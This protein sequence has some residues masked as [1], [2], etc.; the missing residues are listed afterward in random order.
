[1]RANSQRCRSAGTRVRVEKVPNALVVYLD[2]GHLH[3]TG[4]AARFRLGESREYLAT[5]A[6]DD[7]LV[8][9]AAPVG[10][11]HHAVGF[12]AAR[13]TVREQAHVVSGP[14]VL[15][16]VLAEVVEHHALRREGSVGGQ[17]VAVVGPVRVVEREGGLRASHRIRDCG[18][19]TVH[20]EDAGGAEL[21]LARVEGT[22]SNRDADL[23]AGVGA[24]GEWGGGGRRAKGRGQRER[25]AGG[26]AVGEV[27]TFVAER[28]RESRGA[29][30][31]ARGEYR[32]RTRVVVSFPRH[33]DAT[34]TRTRDVRAPRESV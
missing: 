17:G 25:H 6:R 32:G 13:L 34:R 8:V 12:A 20:A 3:A 22:T 31:R 23:P 19:A 24:C 27:G 11:A 9:F 21:R 7:A 28:G 26:D 18:V 29:R 2:H 30:T 15:E 14:R 1:M 16:H 4:D 33:P 10:R 5:G